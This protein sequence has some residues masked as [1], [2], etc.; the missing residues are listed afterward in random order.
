MLHITPAFAPALSYGGPTRSL[1]GLC[2]ALSAQGTNVRV[3][4]TNADGPGQ[5]LGVKCGVYDKRPYGFEVYYANRVLG[6]QI[7]IQLLG[8]LAENL[9]W[10]DLVHLT[11]VYSFPTIPT[12]LACRLVAKPVV[13]SPRGAWTDWA[14]RR[15]Q[16]LKRLFDKLGYICAPRRVM[17][18]ATSDREASWASRM[19]PNYEIRTVP[20]GVDVP[21]MTSRTTE[22]DQVRLLFLGRLHPIKGLENLIEALRLVHLGPFR[23]GKR[24]CLRIA[25]RGR[26]EYEAELRAYASSR[27][28]D[29]VVEFLGEVE[30]TAK[31]RLFSESDILVLPSHSENFG[32]VVCEALAHEVPVIASHRT[33]WEGL[34]AARCGLHVDNAPRELASAIQ[35][36]ASADLV[37][38]GMLGRK[39]V[40]ERFSWPHVASV[41]KDT[42]E[43]VLQAH[44]RP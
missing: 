20:N 37:T 8:A 35:Q 6:E 15:R 33:P 3:L 11:A 2:R 25:G 39:W 7:S 23:I 42:Y 28:L 17:V 9:R 4:T 41:M 1:L 36:L 27:G 40:S 31:A 29:G 14:G 22:C 12:L 18:H 16:T 5:R 19:F 44:R 43:D 30:D 38:M 13:W 10:A 24:I 26:V 34:V 21:D 32:L